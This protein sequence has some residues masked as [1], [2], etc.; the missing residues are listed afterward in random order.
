MGARE[1]VADQVRRAARTAA[2]AFAE[3]RPDSYPKAVCCLAQDLDELLACFRYRDP[4]Q[5][6]QV[7]NTNPIERRFR[8]AV[9]YPRPMDLFANRTGMGRFL[10]AVS[11]HENYNQGIST[12]F[13]V[14]QNS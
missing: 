1:G 6:R 7:R 12:P 10:F 2:R 13:L 14:T 4:N 5:R 3:R 8:E 9:R 11:V